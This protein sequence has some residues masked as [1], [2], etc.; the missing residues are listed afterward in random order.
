MW[1]TNNC[2]KEQTIRIFIL[3]CFPYFILSVRPTLPSITCY[4][5]FINDSDGLLH[6]KITGQMNNFNNQHDT[7]EIQFG[8]V[9]NN[10]FQGLLHCKSSNPLIYIEDEMDYAIENCSTSWN[11]VNK[12]QIAT[13]YSKR[14]FKSWKW[15]FSDIRPF[16]VQNTDIQCRVYEASS[17]LWYNHKINRIEIAGAMQGIIL[18]S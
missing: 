5:S 13:I 17:N 8:E 16:S 15:Q 9:L 3:L 12:Y 11:L 18:Y 6:L 4:H 14:D 2:I 10:S 7:I 1:G